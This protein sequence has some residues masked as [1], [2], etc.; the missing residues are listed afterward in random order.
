[1]DNLQLQNPAAQG[2]SLSRILKPGSAGFFK[3]AEAP[4]TFAPSFTSTP[5][6]SFTPSPTLE[7]TATATATATATVTAT[8]TTELWS[9]DVVSQKTVVAFPN[10]ARGQV[11]FVWKYEHVAKVKIRLFNLS[12]ETVAV[13]EKDR[14]DQQR[15]VWSTAGVAPGIYL[16]QMV[17]TLGSSEQVTQVKKL[18]LV[19]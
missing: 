14:P 9:N 6:P 15:V 3:I 4:P 16:Y 18:T 8:A 2:A 10:P 13:V 12:G 5:A 17:L 1:L 11:T 19:K 7:G